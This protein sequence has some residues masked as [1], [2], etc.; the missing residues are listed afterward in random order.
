LT[1]FSLAIDGWSETEDL[2]VDGSWILGSALISPSSSS[3]SLDTGLAANG[4]LRVGRVLGRPSPTPNGEGEGEGED[5]VV[6]SGVGEG[7][8]A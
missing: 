3:S 4:E 8:F 7:L 1:G 5:G 6:D 2:D